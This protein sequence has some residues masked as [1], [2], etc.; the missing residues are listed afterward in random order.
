MREQKL[1]KRVLILLCLCVKDEG[2]EEKAIGS[3][4]IIYTFIGFY[5]AIVVAG[6]SRAT[7]LPFW[8]KCLDFGLHEMAVIGSSGAR[9]R[10]SS[11][12]IVAGRGLMLGQAR[13]LTLS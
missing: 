13:E 1:R 5:N 11:E 4:H 10:L 3:E 12:C 2:K 9:T 8:G 7:N 6:I